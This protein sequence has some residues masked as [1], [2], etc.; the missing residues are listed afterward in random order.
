MNA[1][2]E[3]LETVENRISLYG[4]FARIYRSEVDDGLLRALK[5]IDFRVCEGENDYVTGAAKLQAYLSRPSFT[6]RKDLAVDYAKVFLSAGI[7]Q[8]GAAF[9]Y[10]SVYTS[11]DRL[12]MQE[13]RDE[14]VR[15]YREK[16]L[17]V[18]DA[19][20]PE[21]HIAFEL[22]FMI[23][24]CC[25]GQK[26]AQSDDLEELRKSIEEQRAYLENHLVNWVPQFCSDVI[27]YANTEFYQAVASMT[28]GFIVMDATLLAGC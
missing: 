2:E 18:K 12:V 25:E 9:P 19:A 5:L 8:G 24:L 14:A 7:P 16:G 28:T 21:D 6:M 15:L 17:R 4:F 3:Y 26:A 11:P 13:A 23:Q 10:E 27:R 22:E 20:E 1:C